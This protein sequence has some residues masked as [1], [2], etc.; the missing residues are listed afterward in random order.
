MSFLSNIPSRVV[1]FLGIVEVEALRTEVGVF[2]GGRGE[3][4]GCGFWPLN[5]MAVLILSLNL[6]VW[7]LSTFFI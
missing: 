5:M 6:N 7:V 3:F 4:D 2:K 1:D